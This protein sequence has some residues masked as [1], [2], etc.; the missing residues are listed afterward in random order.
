MIIG[1]GIDVAEIERFGESIERTPAMLQR[2]FVE[3]ELILPSGE[4]RGVASLAVRFAAKEALAKALGAP[5]GLLWTDAEVYVE[6]S[7]Q[8]RL[9][10]RGSVAARAAELGVRHWH[11]SLSHDAGVASA[12]VIAEG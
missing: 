7:G 10:V 2:L 1:V 4:R 12:V 9:R 11:V 8:P 3:S 6:G 5:A